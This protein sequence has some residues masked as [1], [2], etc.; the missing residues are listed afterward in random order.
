MVPKVAGVGGDQLY[1][2][3]IAD[4]RERE[5]ESAVREWRL[6]VLVRVL[7][8]ERERENSAAARVREG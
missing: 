6:L 8:G 4:E 1:I 2:R 3:V 5:S 7:V